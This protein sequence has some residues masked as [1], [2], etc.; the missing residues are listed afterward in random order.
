MSLIS[1]FNI[2]DSNID[3]FIDLIRYIPIA[4]SMS[5]K[6]LSHTKDFVGNYYFKFRSGNKTTSY[7]QKELLV[8]FA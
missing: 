7:S 5:M 1:S 3:S 2:S 8:L 6:Y 4:K